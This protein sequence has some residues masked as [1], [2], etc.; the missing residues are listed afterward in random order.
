MTSFMPTKL[1]SPPRRR[2]L[3]T[4]ATFDGSKNNYGALSQTDDPYQMTSL[5]LDEGQS[6][7]N[8][9]PMSTLSSF[10]RALREIG[11]RL[12]LGKFRWPPADS[13]SVAD[14]IDRYARL[15]F[16][17]MFILLSTIY[18]TIYLQIKPLLEQDSNL[19]VVA[20]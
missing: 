19:V 9:R 6:D 13:A 11:R 17:F 2:H 5:E 4:A 18:W 1:Q 14:G 10:W 12:G 20:D 8:E 3:S 16:P 15:A 7:D